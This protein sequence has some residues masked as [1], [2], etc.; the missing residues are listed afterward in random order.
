M[1]NHLSKRFL[2]WPAFSVMEPAPSCV[3]MS[4]PRR[5]T[6][7][8]VAQLANVSIATVSRVLHTQARGEQRGR[9][10]KET[11]EKVLDAARM[12][13]YQPSELGRSL[14]TAKTRLVAFLVPD[15]AN[16]F[17]ADVAV[18]LQAALRSHGLAMMLC[19]AAEDPD[20]QDEYLTEIT[21][22][23]VT[24]M[25]MLAAF[26]TP[27]LRVAVQDSTPFLFVNRRPPKGVKGHFVGIDN[28]AA[29]RH[30]AEYFL[31]QKYTDCAIIHWPHSDA[32]RER[33][34][35][36][37][38]RLAEAGV[39]VPSGRRI[40][41]RLTIEDGYRQAKK[42]LS[43]SK[44]PRALFCGNDQVAYGVYRAC[45][46]V[47]LRVHDDVAIFGFDDNHIN[48]WLAPWLNTVHVPATA[49]GPA[50]ADL[51][52]KITEHHAHTP[53]EVLLPFELNIRRPA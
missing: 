8:D 12:L 15:V 1:S 31:T 22:F 3:Q 26:D 29:G 23:R 16:D 6:V 19:N 53:R 18:S 49:F 21:A 30:V 7:F 13:G 2:N 38:D 42:L 4:V 10:S 48:E 46:E 50:I 44:K 45:G 24:A 14:R 35:G 5:P 47:G 11:A 41:A 25:V 9:F 33:V 40:E 28:R 27:R 52:V 17:C 43:R 32:V 36:F 37:I 51:L 39:A 34:V 20:V